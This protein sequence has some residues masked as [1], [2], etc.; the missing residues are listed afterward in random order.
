MKR[1]AELEGDIET[2]R[3]VRMEVA[4][5]GFASGT[6]STQSGSKSYTRI[7]LPKL[8]ELIEELTRELEKNQSLLLFNTTSPMKTIPTIWSE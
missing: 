4:S 8:T 1:I 5:S 6:L 7:D 3:R 2:L